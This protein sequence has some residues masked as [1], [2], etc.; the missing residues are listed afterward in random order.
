VPLGGGAPRA[1]VER[2]YGADWAP[3]G[4]ELAV[5]RMLKPRDHTLEY[6]PGTVLARSSKTQ[7]ILSPRMSPGGDLVA[8]TSQD[9]E[10][11]VVDRSGARRTLAA[12]L[13]RGANSLVWSPK[14]DEIWFGASFHGDEWAIYAVDLRGRRRVVA[15][16][17]FA[18]HLHDVLPDGRALVTLHW[19][20][21]EIWARAP[22]SAEEKDISWLDWSWPNELSED[23]RLLL[24][25]E[26]G[27]GGA[28]TQS[29]YIRVTDGSAPAVLAVQLG[30]VLVEGE[31][32]FLAPDGSQLVVKEDARPAEL[33]LVPTG[34][35]QER[36]IR[37]P[38]RIEYLP[39]AAD[40]ALRSGWLISGSRFVLHGREPGRL[41]RT[42]LFGLDAETLRPI[43]PE[44]RLV[45]AIS[46]DGALAVARD[47]SQR[48]VVYS[49][50]GS[51]PRMAAGGPERAT[52]M[53]CS[54][55]GKA[56]F[57]RE[58]DETAGLGLRVF[59]RDLATGRRELWKEV[60]PRDQTG[61]VGLNLIVSADER[62]YAY[63]LVRSFSSLYLVEGLR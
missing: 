55:D 27:H 42:W 9:F 8:F 63:G 52:I 30:G 39:V 33:R 6:P 44:G 21:G 37:I 48:L 51:E 38:P 58:R 12:G 7:P 17:P 59:R 28:R 49:V 43:T 56:V 18:S 50:A 11:S 62:A 14:G 3:D 45:A 32:A 16:L 41:P 35:G 2:V 1:L 54:A 26:H 34:P 10:V 53:S 61:L 23:G 19:E 47:E 20:R 4:H 60:R 22:G 31:D 40:R 24:F 15:E 46:P 5:A 29:S 25:W 13:K 57:V 36:T